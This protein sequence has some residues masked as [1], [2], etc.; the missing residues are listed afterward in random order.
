MNRPGIL[1]AMVEDGE[2]RSGD[3][4]SP[5]VPWWSLTKTAIAGAALAL[6][7][8]GPLDLD[9]PLPGRAFTLRQLLQHT[10]GVPDYG[11]LPAYQDAVAR[12]EP[13]W[14]EDE[15]LRRVGLGAPL[16]PP[17]EGWAYSNV[18]YLL[19]RRLV[20]ETAGTDLEAALRHLVFMPLGIMGVWLAREP[21]DLAGT[22]W[23]NDA[24]YH[25]G[26][27]YHGLLVSTPVDAALFVHRLLATSFLPAELLDAMRARRALGGPI[28]GRPW[29][30]TGYGLGL[31]IDVE[32]RH[33]ACLGH[34]GRGPGSVAA[35]YHFPDREPPCTTAAFAP[36]EDE[37]I[38]E[39]TALAL[40]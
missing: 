28:A 3:R 16:F 6:V 4:L 32:S 10:A 39:Q 17:G 20:E 36:V 8:D 26:W 14:S 21:G 29:R 2:V 15:L 18:G 19:V 13:P 23:G 37:A 27:V 5:A 22:A 34:T 33:G 31:M 1:T 7:A 35:A 9:A 11:S 24:H 40:P 30:T 38:A 25:P 12:G